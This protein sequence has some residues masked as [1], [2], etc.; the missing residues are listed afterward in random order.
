MKPAAGGGA[1]TGNVAAVLGDLRLDQND[2][3]HGSSPRRKR[4]ALM[5]RSLLPYC[6]SLFSENQPKKRKFSNFLI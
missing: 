6:M 2:I 3:Q 1:G 4:G 5:P